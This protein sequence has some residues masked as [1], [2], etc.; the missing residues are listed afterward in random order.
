MAL[1]APMNLN[2]SCLIGYHSQVH[3]SG[4]VEVPPA[5]LPEVAR[6]L[7]LPIQG[8]ICVHGLKRICESL[9]IGSDG[10]DVGL[11]TD[12]KQTGF[13]LDPDREESELTISNLLHVCG[14]PVY[15]HRLLDI[16]DKG[17]PRALHDAF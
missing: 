14:M 10:V 2:G 12:T 11:V 1:T 17:Y 3:G 6:T 13:L 15:P 4:C 8:P 5:D 9:D 7:Y 16:R